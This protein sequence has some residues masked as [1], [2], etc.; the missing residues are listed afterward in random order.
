MQENVFP[1]V[2]LSEITIKPPTYL[3]IPLSWIK[4]AWKNLRH[5]QNI[6]LLS[7]SCSHVL[8]KWLCKATQETALWIKEKLWIQKTWNL[9]FSSNYYPS[10]TTWLLCAVSLPPYEWKYYLFSLMICCEQY[11][12]LSWPYSPVDRNIG[13]TS[14]G[15]RFDFRHGGFQPSTTKVPGDWTPSSDFSGPRPGK[16]YTDVYAAK[17]SHINKIK[18]NKDIN[19]THWDPVTNWTLESNC[20][21]LYIAVT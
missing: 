1:I 18:I 7:C 5:L 6:Q 11:Q 19:R 9:L 21:M 4:W 2:R 12:V 10:Q 20:Q 3:E 13:C 15:A 14:R 17:T 8:G 16:C